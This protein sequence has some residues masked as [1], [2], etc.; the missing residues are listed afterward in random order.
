[1]TVP[2]AAEYVSRL[3][4]ASAEEMDRSVWL[5]AL[6]SL[7]EGVRERIHLAYLEVYQTTW[8]LLQTQQN[9]ASGSATGSGE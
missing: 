6:Q 5:L 8:K 3:T 7:D 9:D 4:A 1:M 2:Q